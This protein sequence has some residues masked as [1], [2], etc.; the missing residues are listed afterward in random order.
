MQQLERMGIPG[1]RRKKKAK[2]WR[3]ENDTKT[4]LYNEGECIWSPLKDGA[5]NDADQF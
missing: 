5:D 3:I 1:A 2:R 4:G